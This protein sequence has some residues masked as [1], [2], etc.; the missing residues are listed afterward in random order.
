MLNGLPRRNSQIFINGWLNQNNCSRPYHAPNIHPPL[1][2]T[3]RENGPVVA[4]G[5]KEL[6]GSFNHLF[7]LPK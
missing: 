7:I 5:H 2:E 3:V 6:T 4:T 1:P